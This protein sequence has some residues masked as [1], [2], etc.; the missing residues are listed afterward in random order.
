MQ[1]W[2]ARL[3]AGRDGDRR[4]SL[5]WREV[6]GR[7]FGRNRLPARAVVAD[8]D[9]AWLLLGVRASVVDF[10][11]IL[12][13]TSGYPAVRSWVCDHPL[14]AL[15]LRDDIPAIAT[16]YDWLDGHRGSQLYL[17][18]ISAPGVDTKFA[19]RHRSV[20]AAMLGC[21]PRRAPS[22][23][24]SACGP[25][26]V[27]AA[28]AGAA[29][30]Q[31]RSFEGVAAGLS[32][33]AVRA[34]EAATMAIEPRRALVVENEVS[35]LSVDVPDDGV[36]IWGKGFD[37]D[38][39][40]RLPWL[41][42]RWCVIGATSTRTALRSST[43]CGRGC[44][45]PDRCSWISTPL[46]TIGI[47][48]CGRND[49]QSSLT[50]LTREEGDLYDDLVSDRLGDRVRLEQERIDWTWAQPQLDSCGSASHEGVAGD[51]GAAAVTS[52][53]QHV[54]GG[55]EQRRPTSG[56]R[57]GSSA[58]TSVRLKSG[59]SAVRS[60]PWPPPTAHGRPLS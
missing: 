47:D 15:E 45:A 52:R 25:S 23:T 29:L 2:V 22:W 9:Q 16:A 34:D 27:R 56:T 20:L 49:P 8:L 14:R 37:V 31:P 1:E 10:E 19:E 38:R 40:G 53:A 32:E 33:L 17:R 30:S 11:Q 35:Y 13:W 18:Q 41:A 4:Y 7:S 44:R 50:R 28:A 6:G 42:G 59:R 48:G 39:V 26:R 43:G 57:P 58:G 24:A 55:C 12:R 60:R 5:Q 3:D 21:Q 54:A 36:V 51:A 46:C